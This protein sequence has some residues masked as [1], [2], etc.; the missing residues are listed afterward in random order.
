MPVLAGASAFE[1]LTRRHAIKLTPTVSCSVE[2]ASLA[3]GKAVGYEH[4]KS[5]SRMNGAIIIFLSSTEK[6]AEVVESGVVI[7]NTFTP[8]LPLVSPAK[9]VIISNAPPFIGNETIANEL[10]RFGQLVSPINSV[11]KS[12]GTS[13]P[14]RY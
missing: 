13:V 10:S 2:E 11:V 5:A 7:L 8:V 14:S 4:I 12:P 9:R 3:V 1:Q 6:V